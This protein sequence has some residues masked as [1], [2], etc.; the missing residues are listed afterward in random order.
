ISVRS[1]HHIRQSKTYPFVSVNKSVVVSQRLQQ[2]RCFFNQ[3]VVVAILWSENGGLQQSPVS[4][5][6]ESAEF[7]DEQAVGFNGFSHSRVN[8]NWHLLSQKMEELAVLLDGLTNVG[9]DFRANGVLCWSHVLD[10]MFRSPLQ[11]IGGRLTVVLRQ[12]GQIIIELGSH[13]ES[14]F[15]GCHTSS[16]N[17]SIITLNILPS[18]II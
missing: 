2:S 15:S 10:V 11:Y 6:W 8:A 14:D 12:F 4:D 13:I 18:R 1:K 17:E 9:H 16:L 7:L 5:T 3:I